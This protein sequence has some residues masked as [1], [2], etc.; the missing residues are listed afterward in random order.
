MLMQANSPVTPECALFSDCNE[1]SEADA[2]NQTTSLL[3]SIKAADF[4][5]SGIH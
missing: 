3:Q 4:K 1:E 5:D 2:Q